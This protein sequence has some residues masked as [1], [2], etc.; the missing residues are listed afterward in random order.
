VH[1]VCI[2]LQHTCR[3]VK[4]ARQ[5]KNNSIFS[6]TALILPSRIW[7][8]CFCMKYLVF[9]VFSIGVGFAC[10]VMFFIIHRQVEIKQIPLPTPDDAFSL[11]NPPP[12]SFRGTITSITGD[13]LWQGRTATEES[14]LTQDTQLAQGE[15][16]E[17]N[18]TGNI[19]VQFPNVSMISLMQKTK[20]DF[21]QAI[22]QNLVVLQESGIA[23]YKQDGSVSVTVQAN[24]MIVEQKTGEMALTI[25][26]L[27]GHV[28]I[29]ISKGTATVAYEDVDNLSTVV[30]L[31]E[32]D[33]YV[34][35]PEYKNGEMIP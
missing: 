6:Q 16:V 31:K 34:Y 20:V 23:T 26:S 21:I 14:K 35:Y 11:E 8:F 33:Q 10:V 30:H 17:T 22:M 15:I 5:R 7:Q 4:S 9:L 1:R 24:G 12:R 13:V 29:S 3:I 2:F 32:G 18:D 27:T 19:T 28:V 25:K